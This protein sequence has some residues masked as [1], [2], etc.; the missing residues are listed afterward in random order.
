M[1]LHRL[2]ELICRFPRKPGEGPILYPVACTPQA[3]AAGAVFLL[4]QACLGMPFHGTD[5]EIR[6]IHPSFPEFLPAIQIEIFRIGNVLADLEITRTESDVM[7]NVTR[8]DD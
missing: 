2:P 3:W 8:Q 6:F 1:D 5:R 4:I 7:I